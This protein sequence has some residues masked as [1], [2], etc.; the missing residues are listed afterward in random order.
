MESNEIIKVNGNNAAF[1]M[2]F[3]YS[4]ETK[5]GL[6]SINTKTAFGLT[7]RPLFAAMAMQSILGL[8]LPHENDEKG[9]LRIGELSVKAADALIE[10]LNK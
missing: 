8:N 3:E 10:S 4:G 9:F 6:P 1:P 5:D 7:I 2:N